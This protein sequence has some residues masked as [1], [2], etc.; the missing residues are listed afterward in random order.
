MQGAP[1]FLSAVLALT[2]LYIQIKRRVLYRYVRHY[3]P[4][5]RDLVGEHMQW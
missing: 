4:T 1:H 5:S 3:N 2:E